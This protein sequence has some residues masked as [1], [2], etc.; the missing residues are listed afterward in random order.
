MTAAEP[1]HLVVMGVS[2]CGKTTVAT[3]L[4]DRLGWPFG[5]GDA[6]HP[7]SNIDKMAAGVPLTDDDRWPW[8]DK[9]RD[10]LSAQAASGHSTVSTCSALRRTYRDVLRE[11][12]GR[13]RF[14]HLSA[15]PDA[16]GERI[17]RRSGHFMPASLLTSQYDALEP[18]DPDED[19][20]TVDVTG[21]AQD[22]ADAALT[23]LE[24]LRPSRE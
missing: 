21:S 11:A 7:P 13:V 19:G 24:L 18:L 3:L 23:A 5:E 14:I 22:I 16:I 17:S 4:A 2:G 12:R 9:V 8:L 10:W 15:D 6:L 20:I 1:Q